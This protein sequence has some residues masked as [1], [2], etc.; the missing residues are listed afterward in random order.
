M[1]Y[2]TPTNEEDKKTERIQE[3]TDNTPSRSLSDLPNESP[4]AFDKASILPL[5]ELE[6][7]YEW[8]GMPTEFNQHDTSSDETENTVLVSDSLEESSDSLEKSSLSDMKSKSN[9]YLG[10][11][12]SLIG[13]LG[14][15]YIWGKTTMLIDEYIEQH[16]YA[17]MAILVGLLAALGMRIGGRGHTPVFGVLAVF[18]TILGCFI[19]NVLA[20][21]EP[22]VQ[23]FQLSYIETFTTFDI[24]HLWG[25]LKDRFEYVDIAFYSLALFFA[26][27]LSFSKPKR[28]FK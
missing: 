21:V 2:T 24:S 18:F 28:L 22:I 12:L 3:D 19:G 20:A 23:S 11:I 27:Y 25:F 15:A 1:N 6:V 26:Y 10:I 16:H 17:F 14:A 8:V 13:S 9:I 4:I 5:E 7:T